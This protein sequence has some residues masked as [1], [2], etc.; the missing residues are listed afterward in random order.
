LVEFAAVIAADKF[1]G[2]A[3]RDPGPVS[4]EKDAFHQVVA[5][6]AVGAWLHA[7]VVL[8]DWLGRRVAAYGP[9]AM[10]RK[11]GAA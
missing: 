5:L 7:N 3:M 2:E 1:A 10:P 6:N 9:S 4:D 8:G 11:G